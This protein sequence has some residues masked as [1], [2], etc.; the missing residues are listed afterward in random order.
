MFALLTA[1]GWILGSWFVLFILFSGVGLSFQHI[2]GHPAKTGTDWLDSFWLGWGFTL[3][4]LQ[5]WHFLFPVN[6]IVFLLLLVAGCLSFVFHRQRL[7]VIVRRFK[8]YL[9]FWIALCIVFLWFASRSVS[10]PTAYDTGF[11]DIQAVMWIDTYP[12]VPGLN[13]LFSSLAF[14]QTSYLYNALLDVSVWSNRA[15]HIASGLLYAVFIIQSIWSGYQLFCNRHHPE[16]VQWSWFVAFFVSPY[17]FFETVSLGG[18]SHFLTDTSVDLVGFLCVIYLLDF[19][20]HFRLPD[21]DNRYLIWR[22]AF[23]IVVGFTLKQSFIVF[24]LGI[25]L[26]VLFIWIRRG[27]LQ[28]GITRLM[29]TV[30]PVLLFGFCLMIPWMARGVVTSGYIAYPQS[31]GRFDVDWAES[32]RLIKE[33]QQM[34][35]INTR[36]RYGDPDEVLTSWSW[37]RPWLESLISDY[38]NFVLPMGLLSLAFIA[39]A[40]GWW[41]NRDQKSIVGVGLWIL[42]PML[43]MIAVWFVTAPNI[44]YIRYVMWINAGILIMLAVMVWTRLV[45][46]WRIYGVFAVWGVCMLYFAYLVLATSVL[47]IEADSNDGLQVRPQPPTKVFLTDSGLSLN[48]PDSH[49]NQCWDIPLPCTPSPSRRI[50]ERVPGELRHGFGQIPKDTS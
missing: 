8:Q 28:N 45:W 5:F 34:L 13:N 1:M 31:F 49:I 25:G 21:N 32:E 48:I 6:D 18:I 35:A 7:V 37:L 47:V 24:G 9:P 20:Q 2:L 33:R 50:F 30:V 19:L 16:R 39:Y 22:L 41:R 17:L 42:F 46:R 38:T 4:L 40:L 14:N 11:R 12:I 15:Y 29:K 27:G 23:L 36:L 43:L 3:A 10:M 44:K 26:L